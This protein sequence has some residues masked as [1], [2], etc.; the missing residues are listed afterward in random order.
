MNKSIKLTVVLFLL[1]FA[2]NV[3]SQIYSPKDIVNIYDPF[4]ITF[5][6]LVLNTND[7]EFKEH[8][9]LI[10][11]TITIGPEK[12]IKFFYKD[13]LLI[14]NVKSYNDDYWA[15]SFTA[16]KNNIVL[17]PAIYN[18]QNNGGMINIKM[19]GYSNLSPG[20]ETMMSQLSTGYIYTS[21]TL[22]GS[23]EQAYKYIA[24]SPEVNKPNSSLLT[25]AEVLQRNVST[26]PGI[27][28]L[29]NP[30][31]VS[32]AIPE[33]P[34]KVI[35]TNLLIQGQKKVESKLTSK[36][37]DA[38]SFTINKYTDVKIVQGESYYN[39][40]K[41]VFNDIIN[42]PK[43]DENKREGL[44]ARANEVITEDLVMGRKA[45]VYMN[46]EAIKQFTYLMNFIKAGIR[47]KSDTAST[48]NDFMKSDE[49]EALNYFETNLKENDF[50]LENQ[51]VFD[52]FINSSVNRGA[53]QKEI[54]IIRRYYQLK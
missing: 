53:I 29:G 40:I 20:D 4:T 25:S 19:E 41:G 31:E 49:R 13:D 36:T 28:Y 45:G 34:K 42:M 52:D 6:E 48:T 10:I 33:D 24:T 47:A 9:F 22:Y 27:F 5:G 38:W 35:G 50:N 32:Y 8:N 1:L 12:I 30:T 11:I 3:F 46:Q 26:R 18:I 23:I 14:N 17:I 54:D 44:I 7:D 16:R 39:K 37:A 43:I 15:I 21:T 2:S 51:Y